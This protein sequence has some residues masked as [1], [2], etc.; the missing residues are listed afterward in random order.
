MCNITKGSHDVLDLT[1]VKQYGRLTTIQPD[2]MLIEFI[3]ID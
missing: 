2:L 1:N 3:L